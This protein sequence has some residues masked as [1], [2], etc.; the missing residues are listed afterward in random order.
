LIYE[1]R[2][3]RLPHRLSLQLV[4]ANLP[5]SWNGWTYFS[6]RNFPCTFLHSPLSQI[7]STHA[8]RLTVP[9]RTALHVLSL[10]SLTVDVM[11]FYWQTPVDEIMD[12]LDTTKDL[13]RFTYRG[14]DVFSY[15]GTA[16]LDHPRI[17]SMP[18][19]ISADVSAPGCGLDI[20]RALDAPFLTNARFDGWRDE[21]FTEDWNHSPD[22]SP[23]LFVA[24]LNAHPTLPTLS[25]ALL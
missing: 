18:H 16:R 7:P 19:L 15:N 22:P 1:F 2:H 5:R 11:P 17:V 13:L 4:K 21:R 23:H 3:T 25:Y 9:V 6:S 10:T 12:I 20:L 8:P 14:T 24:Y